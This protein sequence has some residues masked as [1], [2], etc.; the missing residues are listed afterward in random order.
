MTE[1]HE[2]CL[3]FSDTRG[4]LTNASNFTYKFWYIFIYVVSDKRAKVA[5]LNSWCPRKL[6][7]TCY[8]EIISICWKEW[9]KQSLPMEKLTINHEYA[10]GLHRY[11]VQGLHIALPGSLCLTIWQEGSIWLSCTPLFTVSLSQREKREI[12]ICLCQGLCIL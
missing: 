9:K 8:L 6:G 5:L 1:E 12:S 11:L 4:P 10:S 7:F 3:F 2:F